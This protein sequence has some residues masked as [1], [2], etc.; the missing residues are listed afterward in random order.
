MGMKQFFA[1]REVWLVATGRSKAEIVE[2]T[3]RGE[4]SEQVPASLMRRHLNCSL[5]IDGEAGALL[6]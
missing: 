5:F 4:I 2:R 6:D 3:V 1:S